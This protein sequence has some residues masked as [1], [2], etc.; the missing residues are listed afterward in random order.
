MEQAIIWAKSPAFE[1]FLDYF[2]RQRWIFPKKIK[3]LENY[4]FSLITLNKWNCTQTWSINRSSAS[5][6]YVKNVGHVTCVYF[7]DQILIKNTCFL[8]VFVKFFV[9][10]LYYMVLFEYIFSLALLNLNHNQI[11]ELYDWK[12]TKSY[13]YITCQLIFE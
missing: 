3:I 12:N 2:K 4:G 1:I 5:I 6:Q 10:F 11:E 13:L 9:F 8:K 7:T